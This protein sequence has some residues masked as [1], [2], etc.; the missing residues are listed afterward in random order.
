MIHTLKPPPGW[1]AGLAF[2]P[3]G[4]QL[5]SVGQDGHVRIWNI[6]PNIEAETASASPSRILQGHAG[7]ALGVAFSPDG[8]QLASAG[9]D[10]TVRVWDLASSPP[11][12]VQVL[13]G[14]GQ[15]VCCIAF[16]PTGHRIA[17]GGA[18]RKVRVWDLASGRQRLEFHAASSRVN[19]VAFSSDGTR[20]A[21]GS[22]DRPVNVW[23]AKT[24]RLITGFPG[25]G[26]AVVHVAFSPD[27]TKL[28]SAGQDATFKLWDLADEPATH[29]LRLTSRAGVRWVGGIAFRP[30]DDADLAVA[31]TEHTVAIWDAA[32]RYLKR[33][34]AASAP[35]VI[36]LA[37]N[38][39]G[40]RLATASAG[41]GRSAQIWDLATARAPVVLGDEREGVASIAFSPD[42]KSLATGG[43]NPPEVLQVPAGKVVP[44]ESD[45]RTIRI[46]DAAS[47]K[48][49]R[50]LVGHVG[51][52][53][54][55]AFS[56]D[57]TLLASAGADRLVRIWDMTSA[58]PHLVLQGHTQAVFGL[59]FGPDGKCLAS[60][61]ADRVIRCWE[62][63]TGRQLHA[64]EGHTNW[65]MGVAFSPDG[66][67]RLGRRRS[68]R[69]D[70][71][72]GP[73]PCGADLARARRPR[74]R[75]RIQPRWLAARG[76]RGRWA[77][78]DLGNRD[79]HATVIVDQ[80][81]DLRAGSMGRTAASSRTTLGPFASSLATGS[82]GGWLRRACCFSK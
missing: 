73:R 6:S 82:I 16:D 56:P 81:G 49:A 39:D 35:V 41:P 29:R 59:A 22:L 47:G 17:S 28:C 46:C 36:A 44:P 72:P 7:G 37:Y 54:A 45:G 58:E 5:A 70:L 23:E 57:G 78:A 62:V 60:A 67:P 77:G 31:G 61:G 4:A 48:E 10:R 63:A 9:K 50:A 34:L 15:E 80:L 69:E 79:Q 55:L 30:T 25:H 75:G 1:I 19:A 27:G 38:R 24:G 3:D 51:S 76:G 12:M 18:D 21:T 66:A 68:N 33:T 11:R 8:Q 43:G 13:R 71:G 74:S 26:V 2:R 40:T 53:H 64:L 32:A 52:I 42:G 14:H 65:V 20:I